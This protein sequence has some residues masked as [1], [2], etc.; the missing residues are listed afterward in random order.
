MTASIPLCRFCGYHHMPDYSDVRGGIQEWIEGI[1]LGAMAEIRRK[2][3]GGPLP[4]AADVRDDVREA[5]STRPIPLRPARDPASAVLVTAKVP[6]QPDRQWTTKESGEHMSMPL[7]LHV[8]FKRIHG[9]AGTPAQAYRGDAGY[10]LELCE[11]ATLLPGQWQ[12]LKTGIVAAIP[13][14]YWGHILAR[15]STWRHLGIR[16]EP[17]VIDSSY[18]GELMVYAVNTKKEPQ[19]VKMGQRLAQIIVVPLPNVEWLEQMDLPPG[20][21]KERGYGSSGS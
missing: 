2:E 9:H 16:V 1:C 7:V 18:R 17:A 5:T 15:S 13:D 12:N 8:K 6:G 11:G 19:E 21:R 14:G 4:N 10:D 3:R 20:E